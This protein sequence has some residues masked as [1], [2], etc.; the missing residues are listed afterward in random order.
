[1]SLLDQ[2]IASADAAAGVDPRKVPEILGVIDR[3]VLHDLAA[4]VLGRDLSAVLEQLDEIYDRGHDLKK[5]HG[6]LLEHFRNLLVAKIGRNPERLIELPGHELAQLQSQVTDV[7][8]AR[9]EQVFELLLR[10]EGALK[11]AAQPKLVL[12][13]AFVRMLQAAPVLPIEALIAK[14][15]GLRNGLAEPPAGTPPAQSAVP[16]QEVRATPAPPSPPPATPAAETHHE[17]DESL[18]Q[19]WQHVLQKLSGRDP[20]LKAVLAAGDLLR[21]DETVVEIQLCGS[22]FSL[23]RV[24]R[25]E[26]IALIEALCSEYFGGPRK[27][28]LRTQEQ[29]R[30]DEREK[31]REAA[32][33]KHEALHHPLVSEAIE[34]F[35]GRVVEVKIL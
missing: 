6:D 3:K 20:A 17:P 16:R 28:V 18:A 23:D 5:L 7:P 21:V 4:A 32:R 1:L 15:D 31:Q 14:I 22:T 10:E 11:Y 25:K 26:S 12:E 9:L 27:L 19:S 8:A 30:D 35:D 29:A 24:R 13:M 34:V 33:L 2:V